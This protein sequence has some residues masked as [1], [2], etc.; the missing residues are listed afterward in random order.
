MNRN[1]IQ[2]HKIIFFP[3]NSS[4]VFNY[5]YSSI[6]LNNYEIIT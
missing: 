6:S 5:F 1:N 2:A 4:V 3:E